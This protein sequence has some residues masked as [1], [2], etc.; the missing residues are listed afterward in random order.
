MSFFVKWVVIFLLCFSQLVPLTCKLFGD[1]KLGNI[2][3]NSVKQTT[4]CKQESQIQ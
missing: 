1:T 3:I 4:I 2:F